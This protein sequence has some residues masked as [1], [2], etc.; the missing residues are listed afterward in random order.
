MSNRK[1]V[2]S[3]KYCE[4]EEC[5]KIVSDI[6]R[7]NNI[8]EICASLLYNRGYRTAEEASKF[9]NFSDVVMYSPLL[10]KD[11]EKAVERIRLAVENNEK[12][13]NA[14]A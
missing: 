13:A 10:L 4:N 12:I 7:G 11:V 6:A 14:I 9:L 1:T 5:K 3:H 8:S 2:W